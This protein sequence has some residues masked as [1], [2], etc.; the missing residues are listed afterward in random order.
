MNK[1]R[2]NIVK[3]FVLLSVSASFFSI[4]YFLFM[5]KSN[6]S[7]KCVPSNVK[8]EN[9]TDKSAQVSW[10]IDSNCTSYLKYGT[11]RNVL[12][13][14][15]APSSKHG[16]TLT[17]NLDKLNSSQKYYF[18]IVSNGVDYGDQGM[19]LYFTTLETF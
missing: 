19:P 10:S 6:D 13:R 4:I 1:I 8:I 9:L 7:T 14:L 11:D 2:I 12:D 18:V 16:D 3:I 15:K 17:T 5:Y